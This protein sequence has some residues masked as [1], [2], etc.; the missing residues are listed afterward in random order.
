MALKDRIAIDT[1]VFLSA[2]RF[3][4]QATYN[5]TTIEGIFDKAGSEE[6]IGG[7]MFQIAEDTFTCASTDVTDIGNDDILV[8]SGTTY[9]VKSI[10]SDGTGVT[11]LTLS[12]DK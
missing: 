3:G 2:G 11:R 12:E 5:L 9:Y 6:F 8:I 10:L 4:T 1:K 7:V